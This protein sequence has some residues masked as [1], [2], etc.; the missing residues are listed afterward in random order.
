MQPLVDAFHVPEDDARLRVVREVL[1]QVE[2]RYIRLV[3]QAYEPRD[4][5]HPP[6]PPAPLKPAV[7]HVHRLPPLSLQERD[8]LDDR[9]R[10]DHE[11]PEIH[12]AGNRPDVPVEGSPEALPTRRVHPAA[13]PPE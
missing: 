4:P 13:L 5:D 6:L 11:H 9:G 10:G 7:A 8:R 12:A 2:L 3:S 1:H